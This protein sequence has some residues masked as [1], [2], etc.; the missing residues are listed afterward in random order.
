MSALRVARAATGRSQIL[1][2]EGCYHGHADAHARASRQRPRRPR[3]PRRAPAFPTARWRTRS[4]RRSIDD[5]RAR[6]RSSTRHGSTIAA[7]IIEPL[8]ANYGL[9]PQRHAWL[10]ARG[11]ALPRKP[12]RCLILDEVITGFRIGRGGMA[13]ALGLR[14]DLVCYGKVIGGGFPVGAYARPR[15]PDGSASRRS[16]PVYQ[17]GTL[18]ANPVGMRAGLATLDEDGTARRLARARRRGRDVRATSCAT[19]FA[20]RAERARRSSVTRSLFWLHPKYWR[21]GPLARSHPDPNQAAWYAQ[22]FHAALARGVYLPPSAYEVGFL[23][24]RARRR[25]ARTRGRAR[26]PRRPTETAQ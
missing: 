26:W 1:K 4:S 14:P 24:A 13:A 10:R 3:R 20:H 19:R 11:R 12:A 6:S 7:V 23:V 17:A 22:F 15:R 2:F 8:P 25:D 21:S 18:S 16:G 5:Q 9:L